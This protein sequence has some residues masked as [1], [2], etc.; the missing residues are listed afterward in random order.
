MQVQKPQRP[1]KSATATTLTTFMQHN[2]SAIL[3]HDEACSRL[4]ALG[5]EHIDKVPLSGNGRIPARGKG[6]SNTGTSICWTDDKQ[7]LHWREFTTE[8]NG[9]IF[10]KTVKFISNEESAERFRQA[11]LRRRKA[12]AN[13]QEL[14]ASVAR[15]AR[16]IWAAGIKGVTN[17]Y[18]GLKGL[19][20]PYNARLE[21]GT[22]CLLIPMWVSGIGLVNLQRIAPD[23]VKRFMRGARVKAAYSVI[24]SLDGA[25]MII[26]CEGWSTGAS[27]FELYGLPVVVAFN[28]GNLMPVC[29]ALRS[30]FENLAVVVAGDDDRQSKVNIGR[31]KAIEAAES[32][33]ATQLFP[34]L[35]KCC[36]CTDHNDVMVCS[37]R[38]A[39]G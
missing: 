18:T 26:V 28:A 20:G 9:T 22:G 25:R 13:R 38:C 6:P 11:E 10:S 34:E 32:I 14:Q 12:E 21:Q 19:T 31:K 37:R 30:R 39:H 5:F 1:C 23:G 3:T 33:G 24:G 29:Q 35:C 15:K 2:Y 16:D 27:L 17:E 7:A 36:K 8:D 4:Q